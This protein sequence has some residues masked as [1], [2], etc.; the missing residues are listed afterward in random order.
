MAQLA[1]YCAMESKLISVIN[2]YEK[3]GSQTKIKQTVHPNLLHRLQKN[4]HVYLDNLSG[5]IFSY[6]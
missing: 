4:Y 5:D 1:Y 3:G 2:G 6:N